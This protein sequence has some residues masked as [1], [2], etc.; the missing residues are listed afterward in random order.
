MNIMNVTRKVYLSG[1]GPHNIGSLPNG[2]NTLGV[3]ISIYNT[4]YNIPVDTSF[5]YGVGSPST[6]VFITAGQYTLSTLLATMKNTM[7]LVVLDVDVFRDPVTG[8]MVISSPTT[9][10]ATVSFLGSSTYLTEILGV[11]PV[12]YSGTY[13]QGPRVMKLFIGQGVTATITGVSFLNSADAVIVL[14]W[15]T[16]GGEMTNRGNVIMSYVIAGQV[17][18]TFGLTFTDGLGNAVDLNGGGVGIWVYMQ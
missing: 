7:S 16:F 8:K 15:N 6:T 5:G 4:I 13:I 12:T 2:A 10:T 3:E 11:N 18:P 17:V 9:P 14:P 1:V